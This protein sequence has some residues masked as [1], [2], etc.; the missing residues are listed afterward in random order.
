MHSFIIETKDHVQV[1]AYS[2]LPENKPLA[3][4]QIVHG[5]QEHARRYDHFARWLNS[6][7]IAVYANDHIG[8]GLSAK[9]PE[10]LS[11]FPQKDDWQRSVN[12][13]HILAEKIQKDHPGIPVFILGHSMGSVL[14][15]TYMM[16]Y[17]QEA[18]GFILSG[19]IRQPLVMANLGILLVKTLSALFGPEDRSKLIVAIGYGPYNKK[20]KPN[21]TTSDWLSSENSIVDEYISSPL[22]G[23][24][25][26]NRFY[27]NFFYG[28]KYIARHSNLK[29]IPAAT[30][31]Y[32]LA[33]KLDP[34]G[35]SGKA[36]Q[37]V[38]YLLTKIA[39]AKV[40][41]K[42]Y[43]AGRHEILN[44]KNREE[45]YKDMLSWVFKII[46]N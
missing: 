14:V 45:V 15:Q 30:P 9:T 42:L 38:S 2:W 31:V 16:Q 46:K 35:Q 1:Q 37:K 21:R 7:K 43:P 5:M 44:E 27:Q 19:V 26:T 40:D 41:L 4:I 12:I 3:V 39:R 32:I 10:D 29:Q 18:N 20:F 17:G 23:I 28:F 8:H 24:P 33:G 13:L 34:A 6:K 22:C 11:H 36:P 25:L